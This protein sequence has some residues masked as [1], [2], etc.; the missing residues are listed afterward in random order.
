MVVFTEVKKE[1]IVKLITKG[2]KTDTPKGL[3]E[4]YRLTK[5]NVSLVLYTSG[6]LLLQGKEE[7]VE[8][9]AIQLEKL[10]IGKKQEQ[11]HF[12]KEMGFIIGTDE[13]L[14]GDTFGGLVVAGVK[15]DDKMRAQLTE[16]GVADSK[17][18]SDKEIIP[19]ALKVKRITPCEIRS[20]LPEDYNKHKGKVTELL[21]KLHQECADYLQPGKHVIDKYPGC[22]VGDVK[23]EKGESKYVEIAAASI[24]ARA[25]ALEQ[26]D[27]LS[28]QAGFPIPRGSTH[29]KLALHELKE[30][31][32]NPKKFVKMNF[33]N[34]TEFF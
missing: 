22:S 11:E 23:V 29:V 25:A 8:K 32:L 28:V 34:V 30:R 24:L 31:R 33:S 19:L 5:N 27:Y 1:D 3:Y 14:K 4:D 21:D 15:A 6:K 9:I 10:G 20:L 12:R 7:H 17:K 13:S 18:L 26:L 2:Y 16:L